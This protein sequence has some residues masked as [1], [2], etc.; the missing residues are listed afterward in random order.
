MERAVIL[1]G[2]GAIER[3]HLPAFLLNGGGAAA[4]GPA[5]AAAP[6]AQEDA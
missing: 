5:A 1:A 6:A 2:E 4:A 3:K